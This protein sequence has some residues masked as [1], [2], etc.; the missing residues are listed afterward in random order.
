MKLFGRNI[1]VKTTAVAEYFTIQ[2]E[3]HNNR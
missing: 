3:S 1:R 2:I